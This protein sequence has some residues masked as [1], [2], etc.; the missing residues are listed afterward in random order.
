MDGCPTPLFAKDRQDDR[1][2]PAA[3]E[4]LLQKTAEKALPMRSPR[5]DPGTCLASP[6]VLGAR[7]RFGVLGFLQPFAGHEVHLALSRGCPPA[8]VESG[9][10]VCSSGARPCPSLR[11]RD[12]SSGS[13]RAAAVGGRPPGHAAGG[14]VG[15]E[16]TGAAGVS[17]TALDD[18]KANLSAWRQCWCPGARMVA[19]GTE[20]DGSA[21]A[22]SGNFSKNPRRCQDIT[23]RRDSVSQESYKHT[24][25]DGDLP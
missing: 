2:F 20:G 24:G 1:P 12:R 16:A 19:G 8:R 11:L 6:R 10:L 23:D 15:E 9:T 13:C 7:P 18:V 22:S 17:R 25:S 3:G 5:R 4:V 21:V 14:L